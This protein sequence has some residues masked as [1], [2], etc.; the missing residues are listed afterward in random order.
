MGEFIDRQ[1]SGSSNQSQTLYTN[2]SPIILNINTGYSSQQ[3]PQQQ[4]ETQQRTDV[5]PRQNRPKLYTQE[6]PQSRSSLPP[7]PQGSGNP[8]PGI[9]LSSTV[10][11]FL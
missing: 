5:T 2:G 4:Q 1:S 6:P 3:G 11:L 8:R 9:K 10:T 7:P